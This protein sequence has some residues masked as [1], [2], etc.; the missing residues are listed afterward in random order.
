MPRTL[1]LLG[2]AL[3]LSACSPLPAPTPTTTALATA[4]PAAVATAPPGVTV[5]VLQQR[6]D[7]GPRRIQLSVVNDGTADLEVR[8]ISL[9]TPYLDGDAVATGF[10][11]TVGAGTTVN[12]PTALPASVCSAQREDPTVELRFARPGDADGVVRVIPTQPFDSLGVVHSNDCRREAFESVVSMTP[13]PTLRVETDADGDPVAVLRLTLTPTGEPGAVTLNAVGG[14]ILLDV[15]PVRGLPITL[16]PRSRAITLE[17]RAT[18]TRCDPH[19]VAEDKVGT[20]LP[21]TV[22]VGSAPSG[23]FPLVLGDA[24]R[25]SY[26]GFVSTA[27]GW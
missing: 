5:V 11:Y 12:F 6:S 9:S 2:A 13:D 3:A 8:G 24:L 4:A 26:L 25:N 22:T 20:I 15:A 17:V 7:Y 16:G 19:V 10:P 18:P 27:C 14:T 23:S 1:V 21:I